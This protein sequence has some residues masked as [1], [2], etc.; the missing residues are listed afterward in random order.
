MLNI[1]DHS[2]DYMQQ[3]VIVGRQLVQ[4]VLSLYGIAPKA[5]AAE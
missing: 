4:Y 3:S 5:A 2:V 1:M